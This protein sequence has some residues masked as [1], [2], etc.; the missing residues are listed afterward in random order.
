[1]MILGMILGSYRS[2]DH[3]HVVVAP[4]AKLKVRLF[5]LFQATKMALNHSCG[6]NTRKAVSVQKVGGYLPNTGFSREHSSPKGLRS[7][8]TNVV[9]WIVGREGLLINWLKDGQWFFR[10]TSHEI[11]PT[12]SIVC[13]LGLQSFLEAQLDVLDGLLQLRRGL[14]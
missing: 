6:G 14:H 11:S 12:C 3:I 10:N 2:H 9:S 8:A 7:K 1:M 13:K 5:E 4:C